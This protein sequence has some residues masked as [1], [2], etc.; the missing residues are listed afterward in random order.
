[1]KDK[2]NRLCKLYCILFGCGVIM[3]LRSLGGGISMAE[4]DSKDP[5]T[6]IFRTNSVESYYEEWCAIHNIMHKHCVNVYFICLFTTA[7]T[8]L[9]FVSTVYEHVQRMIT[10]QKNSV[11]LK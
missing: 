11:R 4:Q 6:R 2:V 3:S 8:T 10:T 7:C 9:F 1:M 5:T